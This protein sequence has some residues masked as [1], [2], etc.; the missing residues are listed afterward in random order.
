MVTGTT[1]RPLPVEADAQRVYE[2]LMHAHDEVELVTWATGDL[3]SMGGQE[4]EIPPVTLEH[5]AALAM[6]RCETTRRVAELQ[7]FVDRLDDGIDAAVAVRSEQAGR[8]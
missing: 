3:A 4:P 1:L 7:E 5:I 6:I 2:A 8:S